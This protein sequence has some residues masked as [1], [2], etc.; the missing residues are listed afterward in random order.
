MLSPCLRTSSF[1]PAWW[2]PGPHSQTLW[3]KLARRIPLAPGTMERW[4][5]LDDDFVDVFRIPAGRAS[6]RI[7]VLHGL[8]G[9]LQ[10][11]YIRGIVHQTAAVG[12]GVDVLLFRGCGNEPNRAPRFYHA[13]ETE[14]LTLVIQRVVAEFPHAP[15]FLLGY[16]LGGNV[17]L[18]WLGEQRA[19][20]PPG[21]RAAAAVSVPYDLEAGAR[22]ISHGFSRVYERH[23]LRTLRRKALEK[24][25]R[26]PGL[27]DVN[28]LEQARTIVQ[29]DEAVTAPVHGFTG[30]HDYYSR[31]S[32]VGFLDQIH[33]PT[34]LLSA[35]DDPFLPATALHR[36]LAIAQRN[37]ALVA[38][39]S[40]AGG[41]VGFVSGQIPFR[42]RVFSEDRIMSFFSAHGSSDPAHSKS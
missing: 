4:P 27:F 2:V 28:A 16:S 14:D 40:A 13:G 20:L 19:Q 8:E 30:V 7:I 3:G 21:L 34:L 12:W 31:S 25:L 33:L 15:V 11:H 26:Y 18:K 32:S 35:F 17:L 23:F 9:T 6:P 39:F 24:L 37:P 1:I 42:G 36:V 29:F 38:E 5:T 22:H 10:S 41:H